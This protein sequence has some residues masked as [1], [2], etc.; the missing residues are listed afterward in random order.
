MLLAPNSP[1]NPSGR[2][3]VGGRPD[4][5]YFSLDDTGVRALL[6]AKFNVFR[7]RVH[8]D[9]TAGAESK[10]QRVAGVPDCYYQVDATGNF[11]VN[12]AQRANNDAG[13]TQM[14]VIFWSI[15]D[16][17]RRTVPSRRDGIRGQRR[18]LPARAAADG[19]NRGAD[20]LDFNGTTCAAFTRAGSTVSRSA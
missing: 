19:G 18:D 17:L 12:A 3:V 11:V 15:E 2:W 4:R 1:G 9:I 8:D 16:G 20:P 10:H 6:N 7:D 13:R 14:P 5:A